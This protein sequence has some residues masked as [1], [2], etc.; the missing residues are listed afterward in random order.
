MRKDMERLPSSQP[1]RGHG[2]T[3]GATTGSVYDRQVLSAAM[4]KN[5]MSPGKTHED[6][7]QIVKLFL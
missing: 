6:L 1:T 7:E 2:L 3:M 4:V 5:A